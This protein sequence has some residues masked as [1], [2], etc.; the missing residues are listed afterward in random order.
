MRKSLIAASSVVALSLMGCQQESNTTESTEEVASAASGALDV[1]SMTD[2]KKQAYAMGASMGI[3]FNQRSDEMEKMGGVFD[4]ELVLKGFTD[5]L[6]NNSALSDI[7]VQQLTQAA[8]QQFAALQQAAAAKAAEEN[9]KIGEAFLA[10]NANK[11]GVVTTESG[12]QYEVVQAGEGE[13]PAATD[14]VRV[15]Y[16]GTLID[17]TVFDSSVN[18]GEPAEFPLN[19]VIPGWTEGVQLM[20]EGAKYRFYIPHDLAY[21]QRATGSITPNSTLIFDVELLEIVKPESEAPS[22]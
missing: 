4:K 11:E 8:Q 9:I 22:E 14:V 3:F 7:E 15:H 13:S 1:Q 20:K 16:H 5:S 19:R 12:L 18:R 6:A 21:G 17:G 10:D 2:E